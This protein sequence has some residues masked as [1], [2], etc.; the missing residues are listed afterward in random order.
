MS[1]ADGMS[2]RSFRLLQR[3]VTVHHHSALFDR[4]RIGQSF[5]VGGDIQVMLAGN[6][7]FST[8]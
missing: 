8:N 5:Q 4:W 2:R 3:R 7:G 1:R 6:D